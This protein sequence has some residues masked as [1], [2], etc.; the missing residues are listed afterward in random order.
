[1][2]ILLAEDEQDMSRVVS[3]VLKRQ[4]YEV[5]TVN[6]G[7]DALKATQTQSF[8]IL[9]MDIMMPKMD[10][11]TALKKIREKGIDTYTIMLTA[12]TQL[13]D[14]INGFQDGADDYVTKPFSLRELLMRIKSRERRID[15]FNPHQLKYQDIVLNID[16]QNLHS[17]NDISLSNHETKTLQYLLR[18]PNKNISKQLLVDNLDDS[19]EDLQSIEFIISYLQQKLKAINSNVQIKNKKNWCI[20]S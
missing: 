4:G 11:L 13:D 7:M 12:K 10:G 16:D 9:L 20:L 2:K 18:N 17:E 3:T 5:V 6:N 19:T 15:N 1:M 8:N 14:K